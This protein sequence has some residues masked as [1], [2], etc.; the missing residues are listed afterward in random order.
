M[1]NETIMHLMMANDNRR[2]LIMK[3]AASIVSASA[4]FGRSQDEILNM[5]NIMIKAELEKHKES[6]EILEK[7]VKQLKDMYGFDEDKI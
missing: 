5:M 6:A 1:D 7:S 4:V 2:E 3:M